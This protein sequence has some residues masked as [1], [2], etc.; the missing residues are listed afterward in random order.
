M[1]RRSSGRRGGAGLAGSRR[2][3]RRWNFW[4]TRI[5][6]R[7]DRSR[8]P[9]RCIAPAASFSIASAAA[10][11]PRLALGV[12]AIGAHGGRFHHLFIALIERD[13]GGHTGDAPALTL[14]LPLRSARESAPCRDRKAPDRSTS[15]APGRKTR[16]TLGMIFCP[17]SSTRGSSATSFLLFFAP[18]ICSFNACTWL[19]RI[20]ELRRRALPEPRSGIVKGD[21][22]VPTLPSPFSRATNFNCI[23]PATG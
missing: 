16:V 8:S 2:P 1:T 9:G 12:D 10:A 11:A 22:N 23:C 5:C 19:L 7:V 17:E 6:A 3:A 15:S 14:A 13:A 21:S 20:T 18:A 4:E